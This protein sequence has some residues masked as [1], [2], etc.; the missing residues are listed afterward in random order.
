M[1]FTWNNSK[2]DKLIKERGFGF[3]DIEDAIRNGGLVSIQRHEN[4]KQY[5]HQIVLVVKVKNYIHKVPCI[6][7]QEEPKVIH[8]ITAFKDRKLNKKHQEGEI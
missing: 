2:N 6:I 5:S 4:Q 7:L 1:L 3:D 8:M